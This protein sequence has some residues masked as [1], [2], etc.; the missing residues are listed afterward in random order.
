MENRLLMHNK[1]NSLFV[2]CFL[3]AQIIF[4]H[5]CFDLEVS[6]SEL[7]TPFSSIIDF[8]SLDESNDTWDMSLPGFDFWYC[9]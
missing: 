4:G 8:N 9:C 6:Q 3:F 1:S 2:S 7:S 5:D